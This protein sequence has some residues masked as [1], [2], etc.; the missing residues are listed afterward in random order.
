MKAT[1]EWKKRALMKQN[2]ADNQIIYIYILIIF[3]HLTPFYI[4][5][6]IFI[7]IIKKILKI[8]KYP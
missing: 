2:R 6:K 3:W 7:F 5:N 1:T 4:H 8:K